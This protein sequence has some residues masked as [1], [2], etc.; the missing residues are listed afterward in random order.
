[1]LWRMANVFGIPPM[2]ITLNQMKVTLFYA[3]WHTNTRHAMQ[4]I[5]IDI[6]IESKS[7]FIFNYFAYKWKHIEAEQYGM[8]FSNNNFKWIMRAVCFGCVLSANWALALLA[9]D[10]RHYQHVHNG[11]NIDYIANQ[12]ISILLYQNNAFN[13]CVQCLHKIHTN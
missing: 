7:N 13:Q 6:P 9:N 8:S 1:M 2:R 12:P 10:C 4:M 3:P 11:L 5:H